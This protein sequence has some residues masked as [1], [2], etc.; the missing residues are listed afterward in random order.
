MEVEYRLPLISDHA[1]MVIRI[2]SVE[3]S[4]KIPFKFF[5]VWAD[6]PNFPALVEK[7]W[8]G[9]LSADP[10]KNVWYKMKVLRPLLRQLNNKEFRG[11]K[12]YTQISCC[13]VLYKLIAKVLDNRLQKVIASIISDTQAGFIRGRKVADNV[14][15]D[16]EL[17][18]SYSRK[19]ISPRCFIKV[20]IQKAYDTVDW[21]YLQQMLEGLGFPNKFT[22]WIVE[23]VTTVNY[24]ILINRE[25]TKPFDAAIG[26]RQG[27][28]MSPFLF[29]IAMEKL[30]RNL[31]TLKQKKAFH[32]HPMCS[33]LDLTRLSFADNLLLFVRGDAASIALLHDRFNS[34]S[35][36][37]SL[38]ANLAKSS[39]YCRGV[40]L[41]MKHD[42]H[43]KLG[44][45]QGSLFFRYLGIPLDTKKLFVMQWQP[46]IDKIVARISSWK[47]KKLSYAGR[48]QFVQHVNF[49][50]QAY[51]AQIFI[52]LAKIVKA[53]DAYCKSYVWSGENIITKKL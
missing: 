14:L 34:F 27:D 12:E 30:S 39:I 44:Y 21:R 13:T 7:I 5:N 37:S 6:Y 18:K 51:W 50:I 2:R 23:C 11:I 20:D 25:T 26:L 15:L 22:K 10:M 43:Q 16:H 49:G 35:A 41:E 45:S 31:K 3:R 8:K 42:I 38:K 47:T 4:G 32:Y 48:I 46:L 19:N 24:T 28:Q 53:I 36:A 1:P 33:R 9:H 52:I 29:A 40:S 17:V